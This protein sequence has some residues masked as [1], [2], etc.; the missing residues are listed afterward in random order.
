MGM[1]G[2]VH[3]KIRSGIHS[4]ISIKYNFYCYICLFRAEMFIN[5]LLFTK[6][7]NT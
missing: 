2:D 3:E 7:A 5:V 4:T 1:E 6:S